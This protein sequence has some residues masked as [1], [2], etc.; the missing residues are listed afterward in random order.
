VR[1]YRPD[2]TIREVDSCLFEAIM[3]GT[4]LYL[5]LCPVATPSGIVTELED[6][7][8]LIY[9]GPYS[10]GF[11]LNV[12]RATSE[13]IASRRAAAL[14]SA[15]EELVQQQATQ[16]VSTLLES[17]TGAVE[18]RVKGCN[19][20]ELLAKLEAD[21]RRATDGVLSLERIA[22]FAVLMGVDIRALLV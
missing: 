5:V 3:I 1:H 15:R 19:N 16:A 22:Y 7:M 14:E 9:L 8:V 17:L 13:K 21:L 18:C 10:K 6:G 11:E 4:G 2:S 12:P 20:P